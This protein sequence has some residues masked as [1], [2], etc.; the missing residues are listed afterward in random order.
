MRVVLLVIV[1]TLSCL[2]NAKIIEV[3]NNIPRR[4]T[5]G[6]I[7]NAHDGSLIQFGEDFFLYG[8]AYINCHQA[9]PTCDTCGYLN[10]TF[11]VYHSK[12]MST[13]DLISRSCVPEIE[14]DNNVINYWSPNVAYN[15]NTKKYVMSYWSSQ[16]GFRSNHIAMAIS[17]TPQGPFKVVPPVEFKGGAI[18]STTVQIF[19]TSTGKAYVRY[20]TRDAPLRHIVE[21]LTPDWLQSTGR[22]S[23]VYVKNEYPWY[24]GGGMF[25]RNGKYYLMIGTDCCF[26]QWGGDARIFIAD[27]PIG[28]WTELDQINKCADGKDPKYTGLEQKINPCSVDDP[29]GTNFTIPAQQFSVSTLNISNKQYFMYFGERFRSS[30]DGVKP[31]DYQAWIPLEFDERGRILPMKWRDTWTMGG[32]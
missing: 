32:N 3:I 26:C 12:D 14:K 13:W 16:Y 19:P 22:F 20:H 21:E 4:D 25:E 6:N 29:Y 5:S 15:K 17:D 24:E 7:L 8:S 30:L 10:N 23:V 2:T 18:S 11:S 1:M 27:D 9:G 28:K 31:N